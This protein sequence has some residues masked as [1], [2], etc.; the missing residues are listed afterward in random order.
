LTFISD[1]FYDNKLEDTYTIS[2]GLKQN[3]HDVIEGMFLSELENL[4]T[5]K[6]NECYSMKRKSTVKVYFEITAFLGDQPERRSIN[7]LMLGNSTFGAR[8]LYAV[9]VKLIANT[10][11]CVTA[12]WI[13]QREIERIYQDRRNVRIVYSGTCSPIMI[14]SD[15]IHP[16]TI[17]KNYYL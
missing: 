10:F 12:V 8:Y 5:G 15:L 11:H 9:N 6:D 4:C 2:I 17:P 14:S 1:T 16:K 7:K 3:N 13:R